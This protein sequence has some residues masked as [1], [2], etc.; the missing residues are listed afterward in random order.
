MGTVR[1]VISTSGIWISTPIAMISLSHSALTLAGYMS[2]MSLSRQGKEVGIADTGLSPCLGQGIHQSIQR[3]SALC[4]LDGSRSTQDRYTSVRQRIRVIR[5]AMEAMIQVQLHQ[6]QATTLNL[7]VIQVQLRQPQA[8][9]RNLNSFRTARPSSLGLTRCRRRAD[10]CNGTIPMVT[11]FTASSRRRCVPQ[12][13]GVL[14]QQWYMIHHA[15]SIPPSELLL[16]SG[17]DAFSTDQLLP[18]QSEQE[19]IH[20][21]PCTRMASTS[22]AG[23][24][25]GILPAYLAEL[26]KGHLR[27]GTTWHLTTPRRYRWESKRAGT[28]LD[29]LGAGLD[30]LG[31]EVLT[32]FKGHPSQPE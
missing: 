10:A 4:F 21:C 28:D 11:A 14:I 23:G 20:A 22:P 9:P 18:G 16:A 26:V 13:E 6:P 31:R 19:G 24:V 1:T 25:F 3:I 7:D 2:R 27:A 12:Q 17:G 29:Y 15:A 32:C 8:N 30:S 5:T